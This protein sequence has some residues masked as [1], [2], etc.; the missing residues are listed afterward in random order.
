MNSL[1]TEYTE[2]SLSFKFEFFSTLQS[3]FNASFENF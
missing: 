1:S 2:Y 3:Q